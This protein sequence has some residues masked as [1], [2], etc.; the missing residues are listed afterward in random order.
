MKIAVDF[1]GTIVEH[2][3]PSVGKEMLFAIQTLKALQ[4]KGHQLILWTYREG[5]YL[6]AAVE[7]CRTNGVDFY[8]INRSFPEEEI[9]PGVGR[10]IDCDMFIDDRNVGGFPGWSNIWQL[11]HPDGGELNHQIAD[12]EA[13]FNYAKKK[14]FWQN[15]FSQKNK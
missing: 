15:L 9:G 4:G 5:T 7:F 2:A 10:K 6:D 11:I 8:A 1:D 12:P 14:S 3:Y 13:H